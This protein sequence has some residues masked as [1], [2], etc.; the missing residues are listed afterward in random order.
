MSRPA[1]LFLGSCAVYL[2][3]HVALYAAHITPEEFITG[4]TRA[5]GLG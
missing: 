4:V 5:L 2:L 3:W 1:R